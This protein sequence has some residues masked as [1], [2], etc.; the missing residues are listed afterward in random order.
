LEFDK[1][2]G[3][4]MDFLDFYGDTWTEGK[5][6]NRLKLFLDGTS[7]RIF[8]GL[9][10]NEKDTVQNALINLRSKLDSPQRRELTYQALS[11]CKQ[12]ENEPVNVFL[13]RLIPLVEATAGSI[14]SGA[15]EEIFCRTLLEKLH[16]EI[17]FILR[18]AGLGGKRKFDDLCMQAQ[19]AEMM[20]TNTPKMNNPLRNAHA[21][22]NDITT[23]SSCS[24][25]LQTWAQIHSSPSSTNSNQDTWSGSI[26][27]Q[28]ESWNTPRGTRN[29][30]HQDDSIQ[31]TPSD[32]FRWN[33]R[34]FCHYCKRPGHISVKCF[35]RENDVAQMDQIN[36]VSEDDR[37]VTMVEEL[38]ADMHELKL[39]RI[40]ENNPIYNQNIRSLT[41]P[42]KL[43]EWERIKSPK[44]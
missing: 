22:G 30:S 43:P 20:L 13:D 19:E 16:P 3:K 27:N 18:T 15:R 32:N 35:Q 24:P 34:P 2:S 39:R 44:K 37:L 29:Y 14:T 10:A 26:T 7:R 4:F 33:S 11:A 6:L 23:S 31:S 1:W 28:S 5:K 41:K 25:G 8:V 38:A 40:E 17:S 36:S 21:G 42:V 12:K 9:A